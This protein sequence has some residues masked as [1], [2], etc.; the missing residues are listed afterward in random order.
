MALDTINVAISMASGSS[1]L[2]C[3]V[4]LGIF[5]RINQKPTSLKM[6]MI[7]TLSDLVTSILVLIMAVAYGIATDNSSI[8]LFAGLA[9]SLCFSIIWSCNIAYFVY[10]SINGSIPSDPGQ[11][12]KKS[13]IIC[14]VLILGM[15][16]M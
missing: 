1:M 15:D 2:G 4:L 5:Y 13:L 3:L 12:L 8:L 6:I 11:Y 10:K 16:I 9:N 14:I 7:L